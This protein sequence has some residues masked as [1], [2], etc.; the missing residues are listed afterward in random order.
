MTTQN[1]YSNIE[2][3]HIIYPRLPPYT[4]DIIGYSGGL[5]AIFYYDKIG[6]IL[7]ACSFVLYGFLNTFFD[8]FSVSFDYS[9]IN[10]P[11]YTEIGIYNFYI[12]NKKYILQNIN[13]SKPFDTIN[14]VDD[15]KLKI[16]LSIYV[17]EY[18]VIKYFLFFIYL[19]G[20]TKKN[21]TIK[22]YNNF[23]DTIIHYV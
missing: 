18:Y 7:Y 3:H 21:Y 8:I 23:K 1:I 16:E 20:I 6:I 14:M 10:M 5:V 19:C 12:T 22:D 11:T 4:W 13:K 15:S 17:G 9:N 2:L